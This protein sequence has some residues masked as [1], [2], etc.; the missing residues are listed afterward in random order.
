MI[1]RYD[2]VVM[3]QSLENDSMI[4]IQ[5]L[6]PETIFI[7]NIFIPF[8]IMANGALF[9]SSQMA[10]SM[11]D[12]SPKT[13]LNPDEKVS[14]ELKELQSPDTELKSVQ[15]HGFSGLADNEMLLSPVISKL[16]L[17]K[18][19]DRFTAE[20]SYDIEPD[21]DEGLELMRSISNY[22]Y[23]DI[24]ARS[25]V[26]YMVQEI[27][28]RRIPHAKGSGIGKEKVRMMLVREQSLDM[29]EHCVHYWYINLETGR[30]EQFEDG[31]ELALV[32]DI[33]KMN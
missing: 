4:T 31:H 20:V 13:L 7:K 2:F 27:S 12:H 30:I 11:E 16:N 33:S 29:T 25:G 14:S 9:M 3:S 5:K 26:E 8:A 19:G 23:D 1:V 15:N 24:P 18:E 32:L 6:S 10:W 28:Y 17:L 22:G 21:F